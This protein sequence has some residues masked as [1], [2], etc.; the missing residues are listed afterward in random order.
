[1]MLTPILETPRLILRPLKH[2][3]AEAHERYINDWEITRY[4]SPKFP[5]P[6]PK[7]NSV[8]FMRRHLDEAY[9][10]LMWA[11][12]VK[13]RDADSDELIGLIELRPTAEKGQR[14]FWMARA[15]QNRGYM[16]EAISVTND[17]WF[18]VLDKPTL[19]LINA[20]ANGASSRL[21]EKTNA[22]LIEVVEESFL[23]PS[24]THAEHWELQ[25]EDWQKFKSLHL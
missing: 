13:D 8:D 19:H 12:T 18:D 2:T 4:L 25:R 23:D 9:T 16:T 14:G 22:K 3:D 5:W 1:M 6:Y 15:F 7:G 17:Y 11:I 24:F 10:N 21:K 20:Q